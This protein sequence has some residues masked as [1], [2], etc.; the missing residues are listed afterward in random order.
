MSLFQVYGLTA[1]VEAATERTASPLIAPPSSSPYAPSAAV[2][3]GVTR[4]K[5]DASAAGAAP[6]RS[7]G[8]LFWP[9][10]GVLGWGCGGR[11]CLPAAAVA[12]FARAKPNPLGSIRAGRAGVSAPGGG[13][14]GHQGRGDGRAPRWSPPGQFGALRVIGHGLI[15]A[16]LPPSIALNCAAQL[17]LG[18][19]VLAAGEPHCD[20]SSVYIN[21]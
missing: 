13:W 10:Q 17:P 15:D 12:Q 4:R 20:C 2:G 8:G 16:P 1:L 14:Q 9:P 11:S 7:D 18:A 19:R 3:E 21:Y 6:L 5:G